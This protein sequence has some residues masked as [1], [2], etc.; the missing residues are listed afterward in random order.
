MKTQKEKY[1][2]NLQI[3]VHD[4]PFVKI[5]KGFYNTTYIE[6]RGSIVKWSPMEEQFR[7]TQCGIIEDMDMYLKTFF[8]I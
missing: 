8:T 6:P 4:S 7:E 1:C 3:S 5:R 2:T